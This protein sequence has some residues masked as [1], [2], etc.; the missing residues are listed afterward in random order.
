VRPMVLNQGFY[1]LFLAGGVLGGLGLIA[2]GNHDAGRAIVL[3]ACPCM[4]GAGLVLIAT[5][6]ASSGRPC[7]NS[8]RR[9]SRS[10]SRQSS[11]AS[12]R[13][14]SF[15]LAGDRRRARQTADPYHL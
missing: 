15:G 10:C 5:D 13:P 12:R 2:T 3:F 4:V 14:G 11:G 7:C 1:N 9:C 8:C 6:A